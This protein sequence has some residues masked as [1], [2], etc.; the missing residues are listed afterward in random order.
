MIIPH[1]IG[2]RESI[3]VSFYIKNAAAWDL[4]HTHTYTTQ[5]HTKRD[6]Y[7]HINT[8]KYTYT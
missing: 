7:T 4:R 8:Y 5:T 6:K 1:E 3:N 2:K